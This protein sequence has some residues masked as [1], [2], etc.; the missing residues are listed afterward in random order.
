MLISGNWS[1]SNVDFTTSVER[2]A[3]YNL[4]HYIVD[5]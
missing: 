5:G 2:A 1:I 3:I 4:R